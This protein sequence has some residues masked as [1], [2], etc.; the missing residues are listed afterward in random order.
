MTQRH[1]GRAC[2]GCLKAAAL[3][4]LA[5]VEDASEV[6]VNDGL[7]LLGLHAHDER[8]AGDAR[9]VHQHIHGA[10]AVHGL[11]EQPAL[12]DV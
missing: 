3:G 2:T 8:V 1:A 7:P 6:G 12:S 5:G 9:I 4:H 10:P 11:L